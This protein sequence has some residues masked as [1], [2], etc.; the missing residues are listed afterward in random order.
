MHYIAYAAGFLSGP[1]FLV[2]AHRV[3]T[4]EPLTLVDFL[5]L[6]I[7]VGVV[8]RYLILCARERKTARMKPRRY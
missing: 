2:V 7:T 5:A 8:T 1:A 6:L 4:G 3:K